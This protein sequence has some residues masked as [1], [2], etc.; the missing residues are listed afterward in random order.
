MA[1]QADLLCLPLGREILKGIADVE[2]DKIRNVKTVAIEFG[3]SNAK[4]V[5]AA[6]FLLAVATSILP[7]LYGLLGRAILIYLVS[8]GFTDLIF[9][10]LS[11]KVLSMRHD[12]DSLKLK[13]IALG[14]MM[15][16]L[17]SYLITGIF[18]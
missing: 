9:L 5:A 15:I 12:S 7:V 8:V 3:S 18:V 11:F 17:L 13:S 2:G 1:Y 16:G 14:G 10:Y 4:K 6:M